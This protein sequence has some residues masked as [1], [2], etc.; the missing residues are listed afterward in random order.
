MVGAVL[1]PEGIYNE[2]NDN[3]DDYTSK[4]YIKHQRRQ[5]LLHELAIPQ[6]ED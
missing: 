2:D 6:K 5:S 3:V 1:E 4:H